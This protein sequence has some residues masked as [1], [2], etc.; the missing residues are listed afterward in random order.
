MIEVQGKLIDVKKYISSCKAR[1]E[2]YPRF[3]KLIYKSYSMISRTPQKELLSVRKTTKRKNKKGKDIPGD[4]SKI[5]LNEISS[6]LIIQDN[7]TPTQTRWIECMVTK[8]D[9]SFE[10]LFLFF[11]PWF[12]DQ[13]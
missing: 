2:K 13:M 1:D 3:N 6:I 4:Y 7:E 10:K 12:F 9:S 11:E 8:K 5:Q